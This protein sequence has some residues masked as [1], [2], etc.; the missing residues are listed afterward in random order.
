MI[1]RVPVRCLKSFNSDSVTDTGLALTE[2]L[3]DWERQATDL[4]IWQL[5][6]QRD[7]GKQVPT[8]TTGSNQ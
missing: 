3:A 1:R 8:S 5:F 4:V 2:F 7:R 6:S